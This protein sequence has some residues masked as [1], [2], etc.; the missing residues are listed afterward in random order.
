M[1]LAVYLLHRGNLKHGQFVRTLQVA[2][3]AMNAVTI[4]VLGL[5]SLPWWTLPVSFLAVAA[6]A[7]LGMLARRSVP[8]P[9]ARKATVTV[10]VAVSIKAFARAVTLL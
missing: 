4:P 5:P 6:G 9:V 8:A 3:A 2:F 7:S 1:P 10:V